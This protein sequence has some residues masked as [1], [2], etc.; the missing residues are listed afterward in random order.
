KESQRNLR[1]RLNTGQTIY[2]IHILKPKG[3]FRTF[4]SPYLVEFDHEQI[5]DNCIPNLKDNKEH[6]IL[7]TFIST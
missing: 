1:I 5:A 6:T 2:K 4:D 3:F 7:F